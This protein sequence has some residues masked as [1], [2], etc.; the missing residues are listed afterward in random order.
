MVKNIN[1]A[2]IYHMIY[3]ALLHCSLRA[4]HFM[5]GHCSIA[6][7]LT[8]LLIWHTGSV[9][10]LHIRCH[11]A[12]SV[13]MMLSL[14]GRSS[15]ISVGTAS[16]SVFKQLFSLENYLLIEQYQSLLLSIYLLSILFIA[17]KECICQ[18]KYYL[19]N[20][21]TLVIK[22]VSEN[23]LFKIDDTSGNLLSRS[24]MLSCGI[25]VSKKK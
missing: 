4:T 24:L 7:L 1:S 12:I 10:R 21:C 15:T 19:Y 11:R 8:L 18:A 22:V 9:L 3:L 5:S 25:G 23:P 14:L 20:C 17:I 16:C 6:I 2:E 13:V